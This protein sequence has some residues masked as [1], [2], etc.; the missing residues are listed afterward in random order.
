[1]KNPAQ[2]KRNE[3]GEVLGNGGYYTAQS[4]MNG[5]LPALLLGKMPFPS[6][7]VGGGVCNN[8]QLWSILYSWYLVQRSDQWDLIFTRGAGSLWITGPKVVSGNLKLYLVTSSCTC[9]PQVVPADLKLYLVTSSCTCWSQ[10]VPA[11][12]RLYLLT[13]SCSCWP[14]VVPANS[15]NCWPQVVSADLK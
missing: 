5:F 3:W 11:D 12:L 4:R 14:Q 15:C 2:H 8:F 13:S 7:P 10:V 1:M 9:W 6:P